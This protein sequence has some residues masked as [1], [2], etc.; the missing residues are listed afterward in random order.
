MFYTYKITNNI[1]GEYYIGS[2]EGDD[3][4]HDDYYGSGRLIKNLLE[5]MEKRIILKRFL[6]LL[7]I[8]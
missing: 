7:V 4:L 5:N 1:T 3:F 2:H 6:V 8:D